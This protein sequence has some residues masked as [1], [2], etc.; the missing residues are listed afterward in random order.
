VKIL[1]SLLSF[2]QDMLDLRKEL[3]GAKNALTE[4]LESME[5]EL[6][7]IEAHVSDI[8]ADIED[9]ETHE[10]EECDREHL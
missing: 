5:S 3:D 2:E 6:Y 4:A 1:T 10:C 9:L 8:K 7:R